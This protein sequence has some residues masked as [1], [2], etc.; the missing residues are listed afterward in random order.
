METKF[1]IP[2]AKH[3]SYKVGGC[4]KI[5]F[6]PKNLQELSKFIKELPLTEEIL[7]LGLGSNVLIRDGGFDGVVIHTNN[8]LN[9]I[10]IIEKNDVGLLIK[11]GAG[12]SCAKLAKFC[13][14]HNL[15]E[16]IW[17]AGIPGTMGGALAM[18]AGAFGGETWR[19]VASVD[20]I[21]RQGKIFNEL[22]TNYQVSYRSIVNLKNHNHKIN[23]WFFAGI[24]FFQFS[25]TEDNN[26]EEKINLLLQ[27]R[28]LTQ[29]IG[30]L[31]CGSVFKNP[32]N[33]WAGQLIET[34]EL[35]GKQLGGAIV[36][37]KHANFIINIGMATADDIEKL[38][39]FI[40][41]K[42]LAVH[43][44]SLETEVKIVGKSK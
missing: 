39:N 8:V 44:I 9:N 19:H 43:Q 3:T 24:L 1:N 16:G 22:P 12:V 42:V 26:L 10:D 2:L 11:V 4:A 31:N 17:F 41:S 13:V 23:E 32:I 35:K 21:N 36:S 30:T 15:A 27:Q 20:V 38:I 7:W 37:E 29:P 14:K 40:Q 5:Y 33:N 6:K 28:K 18:N 34:A 25:K